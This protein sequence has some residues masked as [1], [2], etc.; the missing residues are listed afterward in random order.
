MSGRSTAPPPAPSADPAAELLD[1]YDRHRRRL[2][3]RAEPGARPD[4]YAVWLSEI[5]LQQTT[6][7]AVQK[8][9]RTFMSRWPDVADLVGS[10]IGVPVGVAVEASHPP[11][12]YLGAAIIGGVVLL[13]RKWRQQQA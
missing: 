12:G 9:F 4:P 1:W 10:A 11:A 13:R 7:A 2:P 3:W 8:Y 6:V 5:M